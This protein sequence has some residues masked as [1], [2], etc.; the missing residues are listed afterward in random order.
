MRATSNDLMRMP[1]S[2]AQSSTQTPLRGVKRRASKSPQPPQSLQRSQSHVWKPKRVQ[3]N[4]KPTKPVKVPSDEQI[5]AYTVIE[6]IGQGAFAR[7]YLVEH[8][9]TKQKRALKQM[10]KINVR[11]MQREVAVMEALREPHPNIVGYIEYFEESIVLEYAHRGS[12]KTW[13][14]TLGRPLS[15][16]EVGVLTQGILRGL[17]FLHERGIIHRDIN[18]A[19]VL[20]WD[21]TEYVV[22]IADFGVAIREGSDDRRKVPAGTANYM[23]PE[24]FDGEALSTAYDIWSVGHTARELFT[25][26]VPGLAGYIVPEFPEDDPRVYAKREFKNFLEKCF[27]KDP[28]QRSS[29][30]ALIDDPWFRRLNGSGCHKYHQRLYQ[31]QARDEAAA[32]KKKDFATCERILDKVLKHD[33][34]PAPGGSKTLRNAIKIV[35]AHFAEQNAEEKG[36]EEDEKNEPAPIL[37]QS[38]QKCCQQ[39]NASCSGDENAKADEEDQKKAYD[40]QTEDVASEKMLAEMGRD[41][42]SSDS[43]DT[44]AQTESIEQKSAPTMKT[45]AELSDEELDE[46]L[47][48]YGNEHKNKPTAQ[49]VFNFAK[50]RYEC[51]GQ[52]LLYKAV[53]DAF[54]RRKGRDTKMEN[55]REGAQIKMPKTRTRKTRIKHHRSLS[56]YYRMKQHNGKKKKHI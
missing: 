24:G 32:Q 43:P 41:S 6:Q 47:R 50:P 52:R 48:E 49:H 35:Q 17:M 22:K 39:Q 16:W 54:L 51:K 4:A 46:L 42:A 23:P 15:E 20:M 26:K 37:S 36:D 27:V 5:G 19:N 40:F 14:S 9:Q 11:D 2:R 12:L 21:D 30:S 45:K 7:V 10:N 44:D 29:A 13:M 3:S 18:P 33:L 31:E 8:T 55:K 56:S 38:N 1:R 34:L 53:N 25:G 28:T